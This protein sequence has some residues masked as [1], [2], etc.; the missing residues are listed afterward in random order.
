MFAMQAG[1][2]IRLIGDERYYA[3]VADHIA[4]GRGH[5][6]IGGMEGE[7]RA[8]RPPAHS[9]LLSWFVA[10]DRPG[11]AEPADDPALVQRLLWVQV[12]LGSLLVALT[13]ALGTAL[14]GSRTGLAAGLLA[15]LYPALVVHAHT[16]WSETL[17]A[18]LVTASLL[19]VVHVEQRRD[20][21]VAALTGLGFGVAALTREVALPVAAVCAIWWLASARP[22]QRRLARSQGVLMLGVALLV[23][24]PWSVRNYALF[25]RVIPVSTVG[26]FAAAEGNSLERSDWLL[27]DGPAKA[28]FHRD[29]FSTR[30][31]MQ[32]RDLARRHALE[33][34]RD[35]QP[36]WLFKKTVR[37]LALL[38][39]PDSVLR[40]K[41]RRGAYGDRPP[42]LLRMLLL[43]SVPAWIALFVFGVFGVAGARGESRR[44]LALLVFAVVGLLHVVSNATPRFRVPWLPLLG[45]Y[46]ADAALGWRS[47]PRRLTRGAWIAALAALL[48]F[49]G[50]CIPYFHHYG[51]RP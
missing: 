46:A 48:F 21:G 28:A 47:L 23:I 18:V 40:L 44:S 26:W 45:I 19:G 16:L 37:N 14:F 8:W 25:G 20:W 6:Y 29:Y 22:E 41:I 17:F 27:R 10:A 7:A 35:E 24:L 49:F 12:A 38:L 4:R 1:A 11:E 13:A 50:V 30:D 43:A 36:S 15:A 33:R 51:G 5:L 3:E 2:P 9:T 42:W 31:E 34:I 32:R 39:N